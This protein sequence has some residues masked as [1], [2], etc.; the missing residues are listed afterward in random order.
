MRILIVGLGSIGRRHIENLQQIDKDAFIVVW[1]QSPR[2]RDPD[3]AIPAVNSVV[4]DIESALAQKPDMAFVTGPATLH[5]ET[6]LALAREGIDLFVEKPL[7]DSLY[8]LEDLLDECYRRSLVLMVGYNFRF[9]QS[10]LSLRQTLISGGIGRVLGVRAEVG[11]F[12][13]DWRPGVDYRGTVS[14]RMDLGGGVILELSHELDYLRWLIGEVETVNAKAGHVSDL[15]IDVEDMAEIVL[16]FNCGAI[17]S[18]HL[19]MVQ[20]SPV[21]ACRI[22][23]TEGTLLWD[24]IRHRVD[25]FSAQTGNWSSL[26]RDDDM[27]CS[28]DMYVNEVRHFLDCVKNRQTPLVT[29]EDGRRALEI[30]LAARESSVTGREIQI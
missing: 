26:Y 17:G 1:H 4:Y 13:P 7:A 28:R 22:I 18:V 15:E 23:G 30:A 24:G 10:T 27:D 2:R 21:R 16:K 20:R 29:G 14:A 6:A 25:W 19:D 8:G 3:I 11:Q 5:V 12:L 9:C